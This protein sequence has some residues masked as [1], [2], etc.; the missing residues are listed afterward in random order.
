MDTMLHEEDALSEWDD[1]DL[2]VG[3]EDFYDDLA[4]FYLVSGGVWP[5]GMSLDDLPRLEASLRIA[6]F[7]EDLT[8]ELEK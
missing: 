8:P 3:Q 7:F 5:Q 6:D 4:D 2:A 1:L